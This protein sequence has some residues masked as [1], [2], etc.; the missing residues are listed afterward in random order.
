MK[1]VVCILIGCLGDTQF[2]FRIKCSGL[3]NGGCSPM[4]TA[5]HSAA[6]LVLMVSYLQVLVTIVINVQIVIVI[7]LQ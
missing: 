2:H 5:G 3:G 7:D 6:P 4:Y 1:Y